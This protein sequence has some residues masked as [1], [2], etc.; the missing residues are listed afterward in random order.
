LALILAIIS[1]NSHFSLSM[2]TCLHNST[3]DTLSHDGDQTKD[4]SWKWIYLALITLIRKSLQA[5]TIFHV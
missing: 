1:L 2:I 5:F 4:L 3:S